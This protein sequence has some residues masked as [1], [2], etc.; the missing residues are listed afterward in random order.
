MIHFCK[1]IFVALCCG[2]LT[3]NSCKTRTQSNNITSANIAWDTGRVLKQFKHYFRDT[4]PSPK[5][6]VS[7]YGNI[8][9]L[10]QGGV[11]NQLSN[12]FETKTTNQIAVVTFDTAMVAAKDFDSLVFNLFNAWGVGQ[13]EKNNGI[14][15]GICTGYRKIRIQNGRGIEKI[16]SDEST[17]IIIDSFIIPY[18]KK[19]DYYKGT[20]NGMQSIIQKLNKGE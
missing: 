20:L 7:D 10:D 19:G 17:K 14:L 4:L 13:K 16:L 15:I 3:F 1:I 11:L 8:F 5:N 18:F 2:Q 12:S 6:Y 9:T